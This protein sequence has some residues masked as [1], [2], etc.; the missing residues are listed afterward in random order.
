MKKICN[1]GIKF[2]DDKIGGIYDEDLLELG[3]HHK[4]TL[5]TL[6]LH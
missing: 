2:L 1:F 3:V 4:F 6:Y 5:R